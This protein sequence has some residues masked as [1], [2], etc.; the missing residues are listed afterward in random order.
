MAEAELRSVRDR[1]P[2]RT[3]PGGLVIVRCMKHE[4]CDL[5]QL[6]REQ[7]RQRTSKVY[8]SKFTAEWTL[9]RY[10][11]WITDRVVQLGWTLQ[12]GPAE[13]DLHSDRPVGVSAGNLVHTIHLV[14]DGRYLHAY[15]VEDPHA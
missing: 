15:P 14:S 7:L 4:P 2:L 3:L 1:E 5:S 13:D 9:D 6:S 8:G 11:Q 10:A 12:T